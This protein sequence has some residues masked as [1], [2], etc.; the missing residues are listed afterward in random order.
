MSASLLGS[1]EFT[2]RIL[3]HK[4]KMG[5]DSSHRQLRRF[6]VDEVLELVA[7]DFGVDRRDLR[8][9]GRRAIV[10][11]AK[12]VSIHLCVDILGRTCAEMARLIGMSPVGAGKARLRGRMHVR[13]RGLREKLRRGAIA[14]TAQ[15]VSPDL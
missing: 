12:A 6:S 10:S 7:Q 3:E 15:D 11:Q 9:P 5:V 2:E 14:I 4:T 1:R 8:L 13:S